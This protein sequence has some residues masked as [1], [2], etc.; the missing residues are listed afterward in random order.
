M[1]LSKSLKLGW[2][3]LL[4]IVG[5]SVLNSCSNDDNGGT[6]QS[7]ANDITS[8]VFS[9]LT[10]PV[11]GTITDNAIA[12]TVPS[13]VDLTALSPTVVI[14]ADATVMP[15]TG[16]TQNFSAPVVYT[17]TAQDG[18]EKSYTVTVSQD[19]VQ[20]NEAEITSF[21]LGDL[22]PPVDGVITDT[23][24]DASVPS[25][26]DI[27]AIVPTIVISESATI[28]PDTGVAQDFTSPVVYTVTAQDGSTKD[29]TVTIVNEAEPEIAI[30]PIWQQTLADGGLPSW[31]TANND[32]DLS[33]SSE[34]IYV[35]NNND[36]IRVLSLTDGSDV[37][38]G[39]TVTLQTLTANIST[40]RKISRM[41][42]YF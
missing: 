4:V 27:T 15:A 38:A 28:A 24:I 1:K 37:S 11:G 30:V 33:I 16:S 2:L 7:S 9:N 36:K 31:Y 20:S 21:V 25:D 29:F 19:D 26:V 14:S 3:S 6:V 34:F 32:R 23:A 39:A 18:S 35:H 13:D 5:T 17:V 8:F 22:S 40:E 41:V 42:T 12:V 10:P